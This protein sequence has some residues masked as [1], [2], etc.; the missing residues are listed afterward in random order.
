MA[1]GYAM[2]FPIAYATSDP[3]TREILRPSRT[4]FLADMLYTGSHITTYPSSIYSCDLKL[5]R[6]SQRSQLA[7]RGVLATINKASNLM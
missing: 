3:T 4:G 5:L 1:E 2:V 7:S 6:Q